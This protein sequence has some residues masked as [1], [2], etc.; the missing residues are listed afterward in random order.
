MSM[1]LYEEIREVIDH[2]TGEV[3]STSKLKNIKIDKEPNFIKVYIADLCKLNNIPKSGNNTL[4]ELLKLTDYQNEI[5][6][7]SHIKGRICEK[8]GVAIGSLDNT[9]TR[10]IKGEI[11]ERIGRGTFRLN[12]NLFGRGEWRDIKKLRIE[13][14]Y[15]ASGR[16]VKKVETDTHI[17]T[18]MNFNGEVA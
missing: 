14:E 8:L 4:N 18:E 16:E 11:L 10:L 7:N 5:V 1:A 13:W 12:P 6:L 3:K 15:S 17:Q 9:I 2:E